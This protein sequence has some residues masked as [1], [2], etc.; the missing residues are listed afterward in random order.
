MSVCFE[1]NQE[2]DNA[3]AIKI[4]EQVFE[5]LKDCKTPEELKDTLLTIL[6]ENDENLDLEKIQNGEEVSRLLDNFLVCSIETTPDNL[7]SNQ[8]Q[9]GSLLQNAVDLVCNP[10]G[11]SIPYPY[12]TIDDTGDFTNKLLLALLRLAIKIILSI[13]KKLLSLI[14][15][16]CNNGLSAFNS[17]GS[18]SLSS[19]ISQSI[20]DEVS[21]SFIAEVFDVFGI[22]ENGHSTQVITVGQIEECEEPSEPSAIFKDV[23]KFLDDLSS[24]TTPVEICSLL[25]NK[26]RDTTF[27][28]VEELLE[29]EYPE[30][31][32]RLNTRSKISGLFKTLGSKTD[33]SI[34]QLIED[35]SEKIIAAP[36]LCFTED[37]N[38]VREALLK[39]RN[40]TDQQIK[41]VLEQ[42]RQKTKKNL[43][44]L[45]E[46]SS[47]IK[48]NPN[49]LL[50]ETPQIFCNGDKPGIMGLDD[51][52]SLKS[53]IEDTMNS[54]FNTFAYVFKLNSSNFVNNI[55]ETKVTENTDDKV[56][57]KFT[58][59]TSIDN[60]GTPQIIENGLNPKFM[61]KVSSGQYTLSDPDGN[62]DQESLLRYYEVLRV[63]G[64][65]IVN[66]DVIDVQTLI[67]NTNYDS[68]GEGEDSKVFIKNYNYTN[69]VTPDSYEV[70]KKINNYLSIDYDKMSISF[71]I[72]N[73]YLNT[74]S[75]E[76][77]SNFDTL[78]STQTITIF[79]IT[80]SST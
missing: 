25:N 12:P 63:N 46:L 70:T 29:F 3:L 54:T 69:K 47:I 4:R 42:E 48:T 50:G 62:T 75:T 23:N 55:I 31:R 51:M 58:D 21:N 5:K 61:Q 40:L 38:T 44:Q 71:S 6:S 8:I 35:N 66:N 16:I 64:K 39:Q 56:I 59:V 24:M 13:I 45:A 36:E 11:F 73:K 65:K 18:L 22:N 57:K 78:P 37:V 15:E 52:P 34:C 19:I 76:N 80:G 68:F 33:P 43:E 30:L 26:A 53:A 9:L 10:P 20:G 7:D 72:P 79:P 32:K 28:V 1:L 2:S 67:N 49:K 41:D 77:V 14:I 17:Y 27:Q 60:N 74:R